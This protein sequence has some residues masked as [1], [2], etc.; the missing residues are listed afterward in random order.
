M[1]INKPRSPFQKYNCIAGYRLLFFH[2]L[3]AS[4]KVK[5]TFLNDAWIIEFL[6]EKTNFE[7]RFKF[8]STWGYIQDKKRTHYSEKLYS[9]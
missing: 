2:P 5:N 9:D 8:T 1:D 4:L 7:K 6:K 3:F